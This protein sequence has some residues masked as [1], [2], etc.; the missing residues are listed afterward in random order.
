[1]DDLEKPNR[2]IAVH[3]LGKFDVHQEAFLA[4]TSMCVGELVH[5]ANEL[6]ARR[7]LS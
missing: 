1:M 3:W 5:S 7:Q 6:A 4:Y 2:T